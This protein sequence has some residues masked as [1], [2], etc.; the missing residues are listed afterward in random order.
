MDD[1]DTL[2]SSNSAGSN[3]RRTKKRYIDLCAE[4]RRRQVDILGAGEYT[5]WQLVPVEGTNIVVEC[6]LIV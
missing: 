3:H 1:C 6:P 5:V 4:H 2:A